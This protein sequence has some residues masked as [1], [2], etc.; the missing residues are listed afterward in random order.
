MNSTLNTKVKPY[1]LKEVKPLS[2]I[3]EVEKALTAEICQMITAVTVQVTRICN[4]DVNIV[5]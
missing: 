3:Y 2:F 1:V 4:M 5:Y